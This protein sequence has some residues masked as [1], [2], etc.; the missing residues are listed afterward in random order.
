MGALAALLSRYPARASHRVIGRLR[1]DVPRDV[2]MVS[3]PDFLTVFV[4]RVKVFAVSLI[5]FCQRNTLIFFSR[6]SFTMAIE[7]CAVMSK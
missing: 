2:M 1:N 6:L 7:L 5:T 4:G 3:E